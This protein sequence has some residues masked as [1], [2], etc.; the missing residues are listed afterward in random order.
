MDDYLHVR[1]NMAGWQRHVD[2]CWTLDCSAFN[3]LGMLATKIF[4]QPIGIENNIASSPHE[5]V[6]DHGGG[7]GG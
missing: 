2:T 4:K 7:G 3:I 1:V 5:N 6:Y